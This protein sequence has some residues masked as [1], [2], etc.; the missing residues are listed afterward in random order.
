M[1]PR[2]QKRMTTALRRIAFATW[3]AL[4]ALLACSSAPPLAATMGTPSSGPKVASSLTPPLTSC[5]HADEVAATECG[6]S[7]WRGATGD[8]AWSA[9]AARAVVML[10]LPAKVSIEVRDSAGSPLAPNDDGAKHDPVVRVR[11]PSGHVEEAIAKRQGDGRWQWTGT[12]TETGCYSA[13]LSNEGA[14]A[15]QLGPV[16]FEVEPR[17]LVALDGEAT[18][19]ALGRDFLLG[20][21]LHRGSHGSALLMFGRPPGLELSVVSAPVGKDARDL[22]IPRGR[23][24]LVASWTAAWIEGTRVLAAPFGALPLHDEAAPRLACLEMLGTPTI[25]FASEKPGAPMTTLVLVA[26]ETGVELVAVHFDK[27]PSPRAVVD[28]RSPLDGI[29]Q[30]ILAASAAN[31]TRSGDWRIVLALRSGTGV[32]LARF[33]F[34]ATLQGSPAV[35]MRDLEGLAPLPGTPLSIDPSG[36]VQMLAR[37]RAGEVSLLDWSPESA[38]PLTMTPIGRSN[39][40]RGFIEWTGDGTRVALVRSEDNLV[41]ERGMTLR[42]YRPGEPIRFVFGNGHLMDSL[43]WPN[44]GTVIGP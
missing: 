26:R 28:A 1:S 33:S 31:L 9:A 32:R 20:A 36:H 22:L 41:D 21:A 29:E 15:A 3:L 25:L 11:A 4:V 42:S 23:D 43:S 2:S 27:S 37:N 8:H 19:S 38:A 24:P 34:A 39:T 40:S 17:H 16:W 13:T 12:P 6:P 35:A 7:E 18:G 30:G 44:W 10:G 5:V 14:P